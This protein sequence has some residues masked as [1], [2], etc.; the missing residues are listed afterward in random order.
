[1]E[2]ENGKVLYGVVY[3]FGTSYGYSHPW[4]LSK[5]NYHVSEI[6]SECA[7]NSPK[8]GQNLLISSESGS[9]WPKF[10]NDGYIAAC[11]RV[12]LCSRERLSHTQIQRERPREIAVISRGLKEL[13]FDWDR[14]L[15]WIRRCERERGWFLIVGG[16]AIERRFDRRPRGRLQGFGCSMAKISIFIFY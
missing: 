5:P 16:H 10:A 4:Q 8:N 12:S 15:E 11:V 2:M 1:M 6:E 7:W 14:E 13:G 3:V 9:Q